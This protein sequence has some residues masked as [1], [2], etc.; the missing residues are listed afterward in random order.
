MFY[1][2]TA[3][4]IKKKT[5]KVIASNNNKTASTMIEVL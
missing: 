4:G 3:L 2:P 5:F 1:C